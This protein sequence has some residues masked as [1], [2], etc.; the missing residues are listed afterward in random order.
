MQI[1][2][3]RTEEFGA[4]YHLVQT[5]FATARVSDGQE[6]EFVNQLRKSPGYLPSLALV[7]LEGDAIIGHIMLTQTQLHTQSGETL[8]VLLLAPLCVLLE[9][10]GQGVGAKL[11]A[12]AFQQAK[13]LGYGAVFLLGD[14]GYYGRFG[15]RQAARFGICEASGTLPEQHV[16]ACELAGGFLRAKPGRVD[17]V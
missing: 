17:L 15:F 11:V 16:L 12:A 6:Q 8:P 7:A 1:R 3:E 14:E 9:K 13:R 5:A 4:I 10:R 2:P